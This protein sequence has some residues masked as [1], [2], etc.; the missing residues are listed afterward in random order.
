LYCLP[1]NPTN[2]LVAAV[3]LGLLLLLRQVLLCLQHQLLATAL[4]AVLAL[5]LC[6]ATAAAAAVLE[7]VLRLARMSHWLLQV[8]M[9]SVE[10][11][12]EVAIQ[13]THLCQ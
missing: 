11:L 12:A 13:R 10:G 6:L 7:L 2:A 5:V 4:A 9:R 8:A 3:E 1:L